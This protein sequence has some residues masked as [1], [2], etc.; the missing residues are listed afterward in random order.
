MAKKDAGVP[1]SGDFEQRVVAFAEQLGWVVGLAQARTEGWLDTTRLREQ[2]THIRDGASNLLAQLQE[3][4]VTD[5]GT[6]TPNRNARMNR[7][8]ADQSK[9]DAIHAPGK[10]HRPAPARQRGVPHSTQAARAKVKVARR[11]RGRR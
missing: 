5:A 11:P 10:R 1:T 7:P 8:T 2:L 6:S 9:V 3:P 4:A